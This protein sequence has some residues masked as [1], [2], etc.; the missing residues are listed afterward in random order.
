MT[1]IPKIGLFKELKLVITKYPSPIELRDL[2]LDHLYNLLRVKLAGDAEAAR[3]LVERHL[4]PELKGKGIVD[5]IQRANEELSAVVRSNG[6]EEICQ[7]YAEFVEGWC[8]KAVD[9]HLV[10]V[11]L[12][13]EQALNKKGQKTYL[14]A[15][16][17]SVIQQVT[18]S[19]SLLSAHIRLLVRLDKGAPAKLGRIIQKYTGQAPQAA[20]VWLARLDAEKAGA[21]RAEVAATWKKA[22]KSVCGKEEEVLKVWMWG[23]EESGEKKKTMYEVRTRYGRVR[24]TGSSQGDRNYSMTAWPTGRYVKCMKD[25]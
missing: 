6:G 4:T 7:V 3:L 1:A 25:C 11:K 22:R 8:G 9:E 21:S 5:G 14:I 23:V 12:G 2:L 18:I 19:P 10:S 15:S 24:V 20:Q 17:K 13:G 16:L